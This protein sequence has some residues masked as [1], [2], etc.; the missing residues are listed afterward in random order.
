VALV[1]LAVA[2]ASGIWLARVA[3]SLGWLGCD[4]P[5][6]WVALGLLLVPL[7]GLG[8][9]RRTPALRMPATLLL[10]LLLG[11]LRYQLHPFQPCFT[12]GDLAYYNGSEAE[13]VLATVTGVVTRP[14][15]ERD[16]QV[17]IR[18]RAESVALQRDAPAL[19]VRGD[20]LLTVDRYPELRYGDRIQVRGQLGEPPVFEGFNYKEYLARAGVHTMVQ[21]PQVTLLGHDQGSLFWR[22]LYRIRQEGQ[23]VIARLLPE[24]E[25]A[26]LTGILLGVE[27]GIDRDLYDEFNRTGTS[28]IIVISG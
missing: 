16:T 4:R 19:P 12:A 6:Q 26:L 24:P 27:T 11:G 18:L 13:P 8:L 23:A 3:W 25:A 15:E 20:A 17:R 14:P 22:T 9:S 21:Q 28:H 10:F 7:A 1:Y 2:W 5:G